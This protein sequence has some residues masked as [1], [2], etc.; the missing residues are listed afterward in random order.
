MSCHRFP[1]MPQNV[2]SSSWTITI[3]PGK[4][5]IKHYLPYIMVANGPY[6]LSVV[7]ALVKHV[8]S[9]TS[10][11]V[12]ELV[13]VA[14]GWADC[15][16]PPMMGKAFWFPFHTLH[17]ALSWT[18]ELAVF[19]IERGFIDPCELWRT[20]RPGNLIS[21]DWQ[22]SSF[23]GSL[24][25]TRPP[26][27]KEKWEKREREKREKEQ[28]Q[29][30][31]VSLSLQGNKVRSQGLKTHTHTIALSAFCVCVTLSASEKLSETLLYFI[32]NS[33]G[34]ACRE[35][36]SC[37]RLTTDIELLIILMP[38]SFTFFVVVVKVVPL[39]SQ[40]GLSDSDPSHPW[41]AFLYF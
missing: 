33:Q 28:Q 18:P 19:K 10:A 32:T 23:A 31:E 12:N 27:R 13:R 2:W 22:N 16:G 34:V 38:I 35:E 37:Y 26:Q 11:S 25:E 1:Q 4:P 20:M 14:A 6:A 41:D 9:N 29:P 5:V 17:T 39:S 15:W 21:T 36:R 24:K 40:R 7:F 8:R 30:P 3:Q